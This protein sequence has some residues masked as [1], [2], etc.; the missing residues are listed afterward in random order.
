MKKCW[1]CYFLLLFYI[2]VAAQSSSILSWPINYN[3]SHIDTHWYEN[4]WL[5]LIK[6]KLNDFDIFVTCQKGWRFGLAEAGWESSF[7]QGVRNETK[8][9]KERAT[10]LCEEK[11]QMFL[12]FCWVSI[13]QVIWSTA[14]TATCM[15]VYNYFRS[16]CQSHFGILSKFDVLRRYKI[17]SYEFD[18]LIHRGFNRRGRTR[19]NRVIH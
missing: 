10:P 11:N 15:T 3:S 2:R 1:F 8:L 5:R 14:L 16:I 6:L 18:M 12:E 19:I 17:S 7:C 4:A 9:D 13:W